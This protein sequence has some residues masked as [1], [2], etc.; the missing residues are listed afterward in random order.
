M[1]TGGQTP[2]VRPPEPNPWLPAATYNAMVV[3]DK[4]S[5]PLTGAEGDP[6]AGFAQLELNP[7]GSG[8]GYLVERIDVWSNST[9]SSAVSAYVGQPDTHNE[10]DFTASG[11]HDISDERNPIYVPPGTPFVLLWS[12]LS[13]GAAVTARVQY[14]VVQFVSSKFPGAS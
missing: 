3:V 2:T 12:G 14:S 7:P 13:A 4:Q 9:S 1:P 5:V 10:M 6:A 8:Q 11:N